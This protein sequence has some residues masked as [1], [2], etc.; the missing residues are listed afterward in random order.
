MGTPTNNT[1]PFFTQANN[2]V[3]A[4]AGGVDP[5]TGIY[6]LSLPLG[7]LLGNGGRGPVVP[8]QIGYSPLSALLVPDIVANKGFG[9]GVALGFTSYD[10]SSG[11]LS[12]STGQ[13]IKVREL[14]RV[15]QVLLQHKLLDLRFEK[16]EKDHQDPR[17]GDCYKVIHKSGEV[18]VLSGPAKAASV[19]VPTN[20]LS[21]AGHMMTLSWDF[22]VNP[23]KLLAVND[24]S[25]TLLT[26]D[27][28]S[29][30]TVLR[31]FPDQPE[32]AYDV[33][34]SFSGA[35]LT[36]V[37][38]L[39]LGPDTPLDWDLEYEWVS[40]VWGDWLAQVSAPGGLVERASYYKDGRG[41]RFPD[42]AG[43]PALPTVYRFN[44]YSGPTQGRQQ[45]EAP[46]LQVE[47]TYTS[48]NFLGYQSGVDWKNDQ[49]NLYGVRTNYRYG[50]TETWECQGKTTRINR[51]YDNFHLLVEQSTQCGS[52]VSTK[53]ISYGAI[54]G[55]AFEDQPAYFQLPVAHKVTWRD[56]SRSASQEIRYAWD[57]WGNQLHR[58]GKRTDSDGVITEGPASEWVYYDEHGETGCPPAPSAM[59]CFIKSIT[60]TPAPSAYSDTPTQQIQY[61]YDQ[62]PS[63]GNGIDSLVLRTEESHTNIYPPPSDVSGS[64]DVR[65]LSRQTFTY[66]QDAIN[67]GRLLS[68]VFTHYPDNDA[69]HAY[70][71][72]ET[73]DSADDADRHG[74]LL[75]TYTFSA[76]DKLR[77]TT[78]SQYSKFTGRLWKQ[79][80]AKDRVTT[81]DYDGL[82]RVTAVTANPGTA[83]QNVTTYEYALSDG[84]EESFLVTVTDALHNKTRHG[85]DGQHRLLYTDINDVDGSAQEDTWHQTSLQFYDELG[86]LAEAIDF[87]YWG[88]TPTRDQTSSL[89]GSVEYDDWAQISS[90]AFNYD[91]GTIRHIGISDPIALTQRVYRQ[92]K[93]MATGRQES[94]TNPGGVPI[95]IKRYTVKDALTPYS[96]RS[97]AY[98]GLYRLRGVT[99][100]LG[101]TVTY[102]YDDWNRVDKVTLP[103]QTVVS[104]QYSPDSPA[105]QP[106]AI[107]INGAVLGTRQFDGLGRLTGAKVGGRGWQYAYATDADRRPSQISTPDGV[108]RTYAYVPELGDALASVSTAPLAA[109]PIEALSQQFEYEPH[110]GLPTAAT[111]GAAKIQFTTYASGRLKK[112]AFDFDG[113]TREMSYSAYTVD[114]SLRGYVHVDGARRDV[115]WDA[116]DRVR[117]I[118]DDAVKVDG[119]VRDDLNRVRSWITYDQ[120]GTHAIQT[121]IDELDDFG[122][123]TLRTVQDKSS[124]L[125]WQIRQD[126]NVL[127]QVTARTTLRNGAAYRTEAFD[128]DNRNRLVKW[129]C[130]G[131]GAPCDRYGQAM[132]AQT[133]TFDACS[134][135]TS[136]VTSFTDG[137]Q[138]RAT[139]SYDDP[140]DPCKLTQVSNTH[141]RYPAVAVLKYDAAG[142]IIDDGMGLRLTYDSLG[143]VAAAHNMNTQRRSTY[144]YDALNRIYRR[145]QDN[146]PDA[147]LFFYDGGQLLNLEESQRHTRLIPGVAGM[148]AQYS[149]SSAQ[150]GGAV[151]LLSTDDMGSVL[152]VSDGR[153]IEEHRYGPYGQE[154][155][156]DGEPISV[157]AYNGQWRDPVL[158]GY[159][160]GNGYRLFLP[161][162]G[163]FNAPDAY[164]PFGAGGFNSYA[165]CS[166]DP[167]NYS[168]PTGHF[169]WDDL[170]DFTNKLSDFLGGLPSPEQILKEGEIVSELADVSPS[171]GLWITAG[172]EFALAVGSFIPG[173]DLLAIGARAGL[174]T[175]LEFI[176]KITE[177]VVAATTVTDDAFYH[178]GNKIYE[179]SGRI[180]GGAEHRLNFSGR[181]HGRGLHDAPGP[182]WQPQG[183]ELDRLAPY[184]TGLGRRTMTPE[185]WY[186]G[187]RAAGR[188]VEA[189]DEDGTDIALIWTRPRGRTGSE[190][191]QDVRMLTRLGF[192]PVGE[193]G[194]GGVWRLRT[195]GLDRGRFLHAYENWGEG[196]PVVAAGNKGASTSEIRT[197]WLQRWEERLVQ[198]RSGARVFRPWE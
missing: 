27:Y 76:Y 94:R 82:G 62:C 53:E 33:E 191:S 171:A 52:T 131:S 66:A 73:L 147:T 102:R 55:Q 130:A 56:A 23:P 97:M 145:T 198:Y 2:F 79:V 118:A 83:Y 29:A 100:E 144:A 31:F 64:A 17:Y 133:F 185:A 126:W 49:D 26:I 188:L 18:E 21:V 54:V 194:A 128:Y 71:W 165:Y 166:G 111:A 38:N 175:S 189:T 44:R 13:Q 40:D 1:P 84:L 68:Q 146:H 30:E 85:L 101:H 57:D 153:S 24:A 135:I 138:N 116:N 173:E 183:G 117:Q 172:M 48:H 16:Y 162:L 181:P 140:G 35:L 95:E 4:V 37:R 15:E 120:T 108:K 88:A 151:W 72:T 149:A 142:R 177:K 154:V 8:I 51:S 156:T 103:D 22:S 104:Y 41:N 182:S 42:S 193:R 174:R 45:T 161:G 65:L 121:T 176:P 112:Q 109:A 46:P 167:I 59:R 6:N 58:A 141:P 12:L 150:N 67:A 98:D 20:L 184:R 119:I 3:G 61:R 196:S 158:E 50:S 157:L 74:A 14:D 180:V 114:G 129:S 92:G 32:E 81:Y 190:K 123:E 28:R 90:V 125:T 105:T 159:A 9:K 170:W 78:Q 152:S 107:A 10:R 11:L 36:R 139:F 179:F 169:G 43:L 110:T 136:I 80:D 178:F 115:A 69:G 122:R 124:G 195:Q 160:L 89:G 132:A 187:E 87:D 197:R 134:N 91:N 70:T 77:W 5:R 148:Q 168:D 63:G 137:Q 186:R 39:C 93:S 60:A 75:F 127:D 164:S 113:N 19:K 96:T 192:E 155:E 25:S 106:T 143:R 7:R 34:L 86:R 99:D 47:F 163:R